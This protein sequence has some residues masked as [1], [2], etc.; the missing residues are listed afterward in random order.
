MR[1]K[2]SSL[3][4]SLP[5]FRSD[6]F[7][8]NNLDMTI[9]YIRRI[10]QDLSDCFKYDSFYSNNIN[11]NYLGI[12]VLIRKNSEFISNSLN[13]IRA[14][15]GIHLN[16]LVRP[17]RERIVKMKANKVAMKLP[18]A[19]RNVHLPRITKGDNSCFYNAISLLLFDHERFSDTIRLLSFYFFYKDRKNFD[20]YCNVQGRDFVK[21]LAKICW[22]NSVQNERKIQTLEI[23]TNWANE[24]TIVGTALALQTNIY[25]FWI[26]R[27]TKISSQ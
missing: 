22:A 13:Y 3:G 1:A 25:I 12:D 21:C 18:D 20:I 8:T 10:L 4:I 15:N 23:V 17:E 16:R 9:A 26:H 5:Y 19:F 2:E 11:V 24:M 27:R 14:Q 7:S 6:P